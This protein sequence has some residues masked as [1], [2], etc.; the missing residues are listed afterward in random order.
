[1]GGIPTLTLV[2]GMAFPPFFSHHFSTIFPIQVVYG[3]ASRKNHR[4]GCHCFPF[5]GARDLCSE[6]EQEWNHGGF[7]STKMAILMRIRWVSTK[8]MACMKITTV[9]I[10]IYTHIYIYI[11]KY[12]MYTCFNTHIHTYMNKYK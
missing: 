7:W 10:S 8:Q 2:V 3:I 11:Y 12:D 5:R 1:M 6:P 4:N 9:Y